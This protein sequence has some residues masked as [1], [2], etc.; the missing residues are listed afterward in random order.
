[1]AI[2][3]DLARI[4][5]H[6]VG[7]TLRQETVLKLIERSIFY[8][9]LGDAVYSRFDFQ[10]HF[11]RNSFSE[12][13][14]FDLKF[15]KEVNDGMS[16]ADADSAIV[17]LWKNIKN[18]I[19]ESDRRKIYIARFGGSFILGIKKGE[20][21]I[22]ETFEALQALGSSH[23]SILSH[24]TEQ[25]EVPIGYSHFA[26]HDQTHMKGVL[27][28]A[29]DIFYL[30]LIDDIVFAEIETPGFMDQVLNLDLNE[31]S[32]KGYHVF[33]KVEI[34]AKF[35]RGKRSLERTTH[36]LNLTSSERAYSD[37]LKTMLLSNKQN[38]KVVESEYFEKIHKV[39]D[40]LEHL[41]AAALP[42]SK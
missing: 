13:M 2:Y 41:N 10:E 1:M 42:E 20:R 32:E 40:M 14:V 27:D 25:I 31:L 3:F 26:K 18:S 5:D 34:Y 23:L 4:Y 15:I 17:N 24:Q 11:N 35:L 16:Y 39:I 8:P 29:S 36:I 38:Q 37:M 9:L 28:A 7:T 22:P 30:R 21:I 33:S 12:V 6:D 19:K